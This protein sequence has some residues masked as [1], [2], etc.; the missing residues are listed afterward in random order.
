MFT[1]TIDLALDRWTDDKG[2]EFAYIHDDDAENPF[3]WGWDGICFLADDYRHGDAGDIGVADE[4]KVWLEE[5]QD[6]EY[7][8]AQAILHGSAEVRNEIA[9]E[10][11]DHVSNRP[12]IQVIEYR[13][14]TAY[15]H[16]PT[17]V[18][19][20]GG[21]YDESHLR[22]CVDTYL[23]WVEGSVYIGAVTTP[24]GE[25]EYLGGIYLDETESARSQIEDMMRDFV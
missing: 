6:L 1:R 5:K 11:A 21:R 7:D 22:S 20:W 10:L 8:L 13:G 17:Y 4:L 19:V 16:V 24:E 3:T 9:N 14:M 12:E 2:F 25:T 18:A 15:V 23:T